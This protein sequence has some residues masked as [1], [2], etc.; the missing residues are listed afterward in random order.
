MTFAPII[1]FS[2]N[3]PNHLK[4]TLEALSKNELAS[5]SD[6]FIF[7]DGAKENASEEQQNN[8]AQNRIVAHY[9][10][11]FKTIKVVERETNMGLANSIIAGVS[12]V[13]ETYGR[14]IIL[15]DDI[16]SSRW[17]L[18]YMNSALDYYESYSGVYSISANRPPENRMMIPEDYPYDVFASLRNYCWGWATWKDRWNK[19]DW[20]MEYLPELL[21]YPE[22]IEA[23]NRGGDDLT[24]LMLLQK[25]GKIDSWAVR[26]GFEHFV[27]HA[28]S[29]LPCHAYASNIGFDGTGTHTGVV[30]GVYDNDLS[31]AIETP[32]FMPIVYEDKRIVNAF[33]NAFCKKK[34]PIWQKAINYIFRKL[35]KKPPFV[36]K[37]K[38]Y[39]E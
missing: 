30:V 38:I 21:K 16:L 13:I 39:S 33:Y 11:G 36:I 10:E 14:A 17:F 37:K 31:K 18:K 5:E 26:F 22:Q 20:S 6:L 34:R 9:A 4:R 28:V 29:I 35:H 24:D 23:Y 2:Y 15:E 32:R 25:N 12:E 1:V 8:I 3:R 27:Q 19:V 7:C